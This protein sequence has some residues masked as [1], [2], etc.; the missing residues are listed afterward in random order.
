MKCIKIIKDED[1][2][3]KSKRY[4]KTRLRYGA[5]GI[6]LSNDGNIAIFNKANK[7]EYKLPGGGIDQGE[8]PKL[9]F[10]REVM[11]ET[12]CEVE[13]IKEIGYIEERRSL[14]NFKQIS[15]IYVSK[16]I[17]NNK[18]L[19]LTQ[20][21]IDEGGR[22]IWVKP[23]KALKLI[24]NSFDNLKA[25]KYEDLYHSKFIVKRDYDILEYYLNNNNSK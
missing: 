10:K 16:V 15:Y 6:V 4:Y 7:N 20:K 21:E 23:E 12:G 11:E 25:S 3:N 1:F 5:R 22:L 9:A 24:E 17:K 2:G 19:N 14:D 13:I 8:E 18:K